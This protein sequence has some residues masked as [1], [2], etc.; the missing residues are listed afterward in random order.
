MV[1]LGIGVVG[2]ERA[3]S[4]AAVVYPHLIDLRAL[5]FNPLFGGRPLSESF[6]VETLLMPGHHPEQ[7]LGRLE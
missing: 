5:R 6:V 7:P 1:G 4:C 2:T 3:R